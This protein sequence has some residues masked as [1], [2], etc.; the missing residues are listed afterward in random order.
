[1]QPS[2]I[3]TVDLAGLPGPPWLFHVLLVLTFVLHMLFMNLALG[4]S[5]LAA[6]AHTMSRGRAG[7]PRTVLAGRLTAI[8]G[9]G[10][11]L[12]ITTGIAPL[13]FVQVLYQQFFYTATILL[14]WVW[15]AFLVMLLV[16]YYSTYLYKFRGVPSGRP[17]GGVWLWL[18]AVL[19]LGIAMVHVAVHLLQVQPERWASAA[20]GS[21]TVLADPTYWPRLA[22]FV[23][24]ALGFT[25]LIVAWWAA[26][27]GAAGRER[28][29]NRAIAVFAWRWALV[30]TALQ[31]VDGFVLLAL[32]PRQVLLGV[33]RGGAATLAPLT[34]AIVLGIGLL[35]MLSRIRDPLQARSTVTG[36][37][38]A[39]ALTIT[40]MS[41]TRHQIRAIYLDPV[42][43]GTEFG[44]Q[45][46]W[47]NVLLFAAL[48]A[49]GLATV[50]FMVH[51]V[52]NSS[53]AGEE[54]A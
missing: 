44:V 46:Q 54:A 51:R 21:W 27:E 3:P 17:G 36:T 8:N 41:V 42:V 43:A 26:R 40:V 9:Y 15:F 4:G 38:A 29:T 6:L 10:I 49:A 39:M 35:M 45:A 22:H 48:L 33:M 19:F 28:E 12:A 18:S 53:A 20:A 1:M 5:F 14:G 7:D 32:L 31:V 16:G 24:A 34:V 47:G 13:L 2:L 25:A 52:L 23:L 30:S 37:L 11:S 50:A